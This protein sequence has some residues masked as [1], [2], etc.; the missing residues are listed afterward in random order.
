MKG[1]MYIARAADSAIKDRGECGGAVT[2]LL[3]R[4]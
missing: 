2:A 3:M 4:R 1:D